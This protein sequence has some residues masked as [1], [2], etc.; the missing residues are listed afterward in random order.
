MVFSIKLI[1]EV[2]DVDVATFAPFMG[3]KY[4]GYVGIRFQLFLTARTAGCRLNVFFYNILETRFS[5]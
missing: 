3:Y 5:L 4:Q 2:P 1:D